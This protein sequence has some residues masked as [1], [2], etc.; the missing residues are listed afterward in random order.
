L[1]NFLATPNIPNKGQSP[2]C[3][4]STK[5]IV[6]SQQNNQVPEESLG[7][8]SKQA[9]HKAYHRAMDKVM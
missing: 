9:E 4:P 2:T 1:K 5:N 7:G 8:H 3:V 6:S